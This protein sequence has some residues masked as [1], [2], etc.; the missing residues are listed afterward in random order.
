M[1]APFLG[2][3]FLVTV[4]G[5]IPA[6]LMSVNSLW[7]FPTVAGAIPKVL[8]M[9]LMLAGTTTFV[10]CSRLFKRLGNGTPVPTDPPTELV[11]SGLYRYS[12]NP[13]YI[14]YIIFLLGEFLFFGQVILLL[15]AVVA[16]LVAH[17]AVL[18]LEEPPLR[19]KFGNV[20]LKY[21]QRVPRWFCVHCKNR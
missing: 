5:V 18:L 16:F 11:A 8:G 7:G 10:Y 17:V 12:R 6:K 1:T 19:R 15:Y 4:L 3:V 20:Y 14:G 21:T 13:I 2:G 9:L